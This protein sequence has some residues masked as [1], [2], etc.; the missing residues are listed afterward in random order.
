MKKKKHLAMPRNYFSI[1]DKL[2]SGVPA[3]STSAKDE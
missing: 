2:L 1:H 3:F